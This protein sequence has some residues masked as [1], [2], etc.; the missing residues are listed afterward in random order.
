MHSEPITRSPSSLS[1]TRSTPCVEGCCGPMFRMSSSPPSSVRCFSPLSVMVVPAML[2]IGR[3]SLPAFNAQVF[4]H[5]HSILLDDVVVFAQRIALPA[6]RQKNSPQIRMPRKNNPEHV[7]DFALQPVGSR[8]DAYR[9]RDLLAVGGMHFYA[10]AFILLKRIKVEQDVETF[11][12]LWPILS[13]QI[14]KEIELFLVAQMLRDFRQTRA[15]DDEDCLF[16]VL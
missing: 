11:L 7:E 14:R 8:P 16:A 12:A 10:Q 6:V 2:V 5:P 13:G 1:L 15:F 9:A 3:S 4:F